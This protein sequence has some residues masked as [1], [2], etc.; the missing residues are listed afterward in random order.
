MST[1]NTKSNPR[2][3]KQ[4]FFAIS[5]LWMELSPLRGDG[6]SNT[7]ETSKDHERTT[8][9]L[10]APGTSQE[11][12][13]ICFEAKFA[14][15]VFVGPNDRIVAMDCTRNGVHAAARILI[16]F[17]DKVKGC[18]VYMSRKPCSY[19]V[20]LLVQAEVK[21]ILHLPFKPEA[22]PDPKCE[23]LANAIQ[24]ENL[25]KVFPT[26]MSMHKPDVNKTMEESLAST[27]K[28]LNM[29]DY[30][31]ESKSFQ[32]CLMD[33]YW[34]KEWV[35]YL[36]GVASPS[37]VSDNADGTERKE[38]A[39]KDIVRCPGLDGDVVDNLDASIDNMMR[40]IAL[41]TVALIPWDPD[42]KTAR[43]RYQFRQFTEKLPSSV[44]SAGTVDDPPGQD[45]A[46]SGTNG[47]KVEIPENPDPKNPLWQ[48]IA[49]HLSRLALI[50]GRRT[51]DPCT[52]VGAI[53]LVKNQ[54]V[55]V[56]LNGYPSKASYGDFPRRKDPKMPVTSQ[57]YP[58]L[59]HAEQNA[60]LLRNTREIRNQPSTTM[61]VTKTPCNECA[62]LLVEAGVHNVVLPWREKLKEKGH[63]AEEV[64]EEVEAKE[65][66]AEEVEAK[67]EEQKEE[68]AE[69]Q[70]KGINYGDI[71]GMVNDTSFRV[72][73][74]EEM[75]AT[76]R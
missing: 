2:I 51:D 60:L 23:P 68:V 75:K 17:P 70:R 25:L 6:E 38:T 63:Q 12:D 73:Y 9:N 13:L 10:K 40:W 22:F 55:S 49:L 37:T 39:G 64:E 41:A 11:P 76:P 65:E 46:P 58:Y 35:K 18:T 8:A 27:V 20:K 3:S 42:P 43:Q 48:D 14:G 5:A 44:S 15:A 53:L 71:Y 45:L 33:T 28:R 66:A 30:E 24:T 29:K 67:E 31:S 72:F 74:G 54:I 47:E 21:K 36:R 62:G 59:I 56:G 26:G 52:G 1:P 7:S 32:K 19:C 61:F 57:K 50:A 16:N 34:S 4:D 69:E